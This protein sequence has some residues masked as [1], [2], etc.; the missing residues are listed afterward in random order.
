MKSWSVKILSVAALLLTAL[1]V[2]D[3]APSPN[4]LGGLRRAAS[5]GVGLASMEG[6]PTV[7][8]TRPG[9]TADQLGL[10][11]GDVITA[12]DGQ[13][14][15]EAA[16]FV[17]AVGRKRAGDP[18]AL[19]IRRGEQSIEKSASIAGAL[20][21]KESYPIEYG[22]VAVDGSKRRTIVTRPPAKGSKDKF[23]AVLLIGGIGCYS[24]DGLLRAPPESRQPYGVLLHSLTLAGFVTMR[25]EKSGMGDSEGVPCMDPRRDFDA[26]VREFEAGLAALE[27]LKYVDARRVFIFGHSIGPLVAAR[28]AAQHPV[29]GLVLA[30]T[31]GTGWLEYDL[32]NTRRQLVLK[33]LPYDEVEKQMRA[34]ASC[35][36]GFYVERRLDPACEAQLPMPMPPTYMQQVGGLDLAALWKKIDAPTLIFYGTADFITDEGQGRYL[37]DMINAFHPG[38][39]RL[40]VVEGMEHGL[41]VT[42][43]QAASYSGAEGPVADVLIKGTVEFLK[44]QAR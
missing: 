8:A 28:I 11:A 31:I 7:A 38:R 22:S 39:A 26:E 23:P 30:E 2:A 17:A 36:H 37:R 5:L 9:S 19:T 42:G 18:I 10:Q 15:P 32:A 33:G 20:V 27:K 40:E 21:E 34:H 41:H 44:Q 43:T 35:A 6:P 13:P 24:L 4:E 16:S 14:A 25:V 3:S 29:R 1:A 12:L